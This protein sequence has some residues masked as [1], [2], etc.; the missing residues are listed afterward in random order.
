VTAPAPAKKTRNTYNLGPVLPHVR[1]AAEEVGN[2]FGIGTI[3]GWRATARD[4]TGHPA[5]RALDFMVAGGTGE[6]ANRYLID[7]RDR[8]GVT[9]TLWRQTEYSQAAGWDTGRRMEDRGSP[10]QNHYDHIHANFSTLP[11]NPLGAVVDAA[12]D[13]VD[14]VTP[15]WSAPVGELLMK[16][17]GLGA[18]VA[19]VVVGAKQAVTRG[20]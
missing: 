5:G 6:Q 7:N 15:D 10:T 13:V 9:Y 1:A 11:G 3:G 14:A 16:G 8:L 17:L 20:E 19:L 18:A 12:G 4:M 2:R